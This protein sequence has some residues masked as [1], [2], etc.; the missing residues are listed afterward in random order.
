MQVDG[1][2]VALNQPLTEWLLRCLLC[3]GV[4]QR[5]RFFAFLNS[6]NCLS[7]NLAFRINTGKLLLEDGVL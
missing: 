6:L 3:F 1:L 2:F 5:Q 7:D 4:E